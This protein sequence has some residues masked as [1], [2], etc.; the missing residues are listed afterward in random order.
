MNRYDPIIS[1][2]L[3]I[4]LTA[5]LTN[6]LPEISLSI[7]LIIFIFILGGF[8]ATYLSRTNK[9][10]YG[11]YEGL[12]YSAGFLPIILIYKTITFYIVLYMIFTPILGFVGGF[13]G[14]KLRLRLDIED[15]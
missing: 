14:K 9:A 7:I 4:I 6:L 12:I 13:I 1:I 2:I 10:I 15:Q 11:L 3:G 5:I 8:T